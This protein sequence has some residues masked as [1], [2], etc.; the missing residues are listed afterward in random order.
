MSDITI[1][2]PDDVKEIIQT[3]ESHGYEAFAVGGCIRD[4]ILG[5]NPDDWDITTSA[6]PEQVKSFFKRTIDTGIQHGTVTVMLHHT[7][8]E[9]TTYRIDGE[10]KDGS[11][12]ESVEFSG[13]LVDDLQRRDF[14]IN[15]MAYNEKQGFVDEFDGL[16][17]MKQGIIRCVGDPKQRFLEDAL[18]MMRA[19]RF[20]AQLGFA[21]E[22][23]TYDAMVALAGNIAQV[24]MERVQVELVKTLLSDNP[25]Y[26]KRFA[27]SG[28]FAVN[29]PCIDNILTGK[30]A[31]NALTMLKYAPKQSVLRYAALFNMAEPQETKNA[32]KSLKLDN[33]TIDTV[34]KLVTYEKDV[35]AENEP[36]VREALHKYG[37][38]ML[39]LMFTHEH[40][41]ICTQEE[42]L[43]LSMSAKKLHLERIEQ[44]SKEILQRGDCFTI[45]ELDITGNDLK[46]YGLQGAQ[47]GKM[48]NELLHIV[49]ENPK[50]NE[51]ETL[52]A[53]I[54]HVD[55]D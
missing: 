9:V 11:H 38:D 17:D 46:E 24:S 8:Y 50:L 2:L 37:I 42:I 1:A 43:G 7:G 41:R 10:Y 16:S 49:I 22:Q 28:L 40:A 12:P 45:K 6:R 21:I 30:Y 55:I 15:A 20:S 13:K 54:E 27:E 4:S 23:E 14:T 35:I 19:I 31:R 53:M 25:S 32:L 36:A 5:R 47:I 18:R 44:M 48:L 3:I 52:I 33:Y 26:V 51:K 29:L 39:Q 34:T